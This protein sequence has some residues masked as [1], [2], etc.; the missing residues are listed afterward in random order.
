MDALKLN[1]VSNL[2]LACYGQADYIQAVDYATKALEFEPN[3]AK[4]LLRRARALSMKGDYAAAMADL[5]A[6][7]AAKECPDAVAK[8]IEAERAANKRREKAASAKQRQAFRNFFD[9]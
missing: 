8:E 6:A 5:D 4:L 9:R 3:S 2:T 7:A 1:I